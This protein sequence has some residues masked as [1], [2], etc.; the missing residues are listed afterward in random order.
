MGLPE[1]SVAERKELLADCHS[2][3]RHLPNVT[4]TVGINLIYFTALFLQDPDP[5]QYTQVSYQEDSTKELNSTVAKEESKNLAIE[6]HT[7]AF[8]IFNPEIFWTWDDWLRMPGLPFFLWAP[9]KWK[10]SSLRS[11]WISPSVYTE[12][13][14]LS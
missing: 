3:C 7:L 14:L 10:A 12:R 5:C 6:S 1:T 13:L 11:L 9:N 8:L 2:K 4:R